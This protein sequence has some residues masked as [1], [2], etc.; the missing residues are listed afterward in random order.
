MRIVYTRAMNEQPVKK[1]VTAFL[2]S[3]FFLIILSLLSFSG[4]LSEGYYACIPLSLLT[5]LSFLPLFQDDGIYYS[6]FL[7]LLIP[8]SK[9]EFRAKDFPLA[10]LIALGSVFLSRI[11]FL[12]LRKPR[13]RIGILFYALLALFILILA[14]FCIKAIERNN[15]FRQAWLYIISLFIFIAVYRRVVP[16][17]SGRE[18]RY[19]LSKTAASLSSVLFAET[20]A[21]LLYRKGAFFAGLDF[22]NSSGE[23]IAALIILQ[24]PFLAYGIFK[25]QWYLVFFAILDYISMR[26]LGNAISRIFLIVA[27]VPFLFLSLKSYER[28]YPYLLL[29]GIALIFTP[30]CILLFSNRDF[31]QGVLDART[32]FNILNPSNPNYS[33]LSSAWSAFESDYILGP[34]LL[35]L[36]K[37]YG[38]DSIPNGYLEIGTLAGVPGIL[39]YLLIDLFFYII[40]LRGKTRSERVFFLYFLILH[41]I[42]NWLRDATRNWMLFL[43]LMVFIGVYQGSTYQDQIIVHDS[44]DSLE[45]RKRPENP[46]ER[47]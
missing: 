2:R 18:G 47:L 40:A 27:F 19:Y 38:I 41:D 32:Y 15:I 3:P 21:T 5:L 39:T 29:A 36:V 8:S 6:A 43:S 14:S 24:I 16:A 45:R 22:P 17:S 13:I 12:F 46:S 4:F 30:Y 26:L 20:I 1:K 23:V 35:S 44:F 11:I 28:I 25:K 31:S 9:T 33:V 7:L 42:L 37:W 34:S 10:R